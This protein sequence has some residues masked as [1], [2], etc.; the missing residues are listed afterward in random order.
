MSGKKRCMLLLLYASGSLLL[1]LSLISCTRSTHLP[2]KNDTP[3]PPPHVG[4]FVSECGSMTFNGDGQTV[5]IDFSDELAQALDLASGKASGTYV[6]K[7]YNGQ[8]RYDDADEFSLFIDGRSVGFSTVL[9]GVDANLITL[10]SPLDDEIYLE[11]VRTEQ[12][13]LRQ[14][15]A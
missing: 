9:G 2:P 15:E 12:A 6:F 7:F 4:V 11:F 10:M 3:E 5:A 8:W 1:L 13:V 14:D